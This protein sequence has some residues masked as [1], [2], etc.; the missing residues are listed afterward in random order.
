MKILSRVKTYDL[1]SHRFLGECV[2]EW[3]LQTKP[4][5]GSVNICVEVFPQTL[6]LEGSSEVIEAKEISLD[7]PVAL[8]AHEAIVLKPIELV[9]SLNEKGTGFNHK[10]GVYF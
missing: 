4:H 2:L 5:K 1:H 7:L 3:H 9:V 8:P 10:V 6:R